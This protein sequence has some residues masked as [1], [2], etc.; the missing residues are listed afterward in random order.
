M[1]CPRNILPYLLSSLAIFANFCCVTIDAPPAEPIRTSRVDLQPC[2]FANH[3]SA[4]LCG[5]YPVF[6][7]RVA[8]AGRMISLNIV[9]APAT[10]AE[11]KPDPVFFLTGGPGQGAAQVATAREDPLMSELRRERDLIFID[12]RGTGDSNRLQCSGTPDRNSAQ[13][14]FAEIFPLQRIHAC[15][16]ALAGIA[17][18]RF[19][20]TPIAMDDF[21]EVRA[22]L[23][24]GKI[25]LYAVSYGTQAA[26]QYLRLYSTRV[27]SA[28]LAGVT[29]PA[30]KLLLHFAKGAQQAMDRLMDDCAADETCANQFPNIKGDFAFVLAAFDN[31]PVTFEVNHPVMKTS[32]RVNLSRGVFVE[33]LRWMLYDHRTA[34]LIPLLIQQ[35]AMGNWAAFTKIAFAPGA[36]GSGVSLGMYLSVT[37]TESVAPISEHEIV[38]ET[39]GTFLGEYRTRRHQQACSGW[40]QGKISPEYY[41][42]AKSEVPVLML[43]GEIDPATPP[44]YGKAASQFLLNSQQIV[45]RRTPHDYQ[46]DCATQLAAEFIAQGSPEDLD[47][48]CAD[49]I[50]RPRF[51]TELPERYNP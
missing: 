26:L 1:S 11:P 5:K 34:R 21:E 15:Y 9:V 4:L 45:L 36:V 27:R 3:K 22:A 23:G 16:E 46:S 50:R 39:Q 47:T 12:L 43:S 28:V 10:A 24:Y 2:R 31:G 7:D 37:C 8:K 38:R 18:L 32:Q 33:R 35:A 44:E 48:S 19:Y 6:E 20:T 29:T 49:H 25:S 13:N 30:A 51:L 42:P 14:Y 41:Q 40:P 17:D